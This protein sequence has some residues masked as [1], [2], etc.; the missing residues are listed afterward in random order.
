[1]T[2]PVKYCPFLLFC[3]RVRHRMSLLEKPFPR[4]STAGKGKDG[5]G[6]GGGVRR[7]HIRDGDR[8]SE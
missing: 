8:A 2:Q 7:G 1:M 5:G 3:V 4:L 6:K